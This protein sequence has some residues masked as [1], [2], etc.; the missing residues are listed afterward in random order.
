MAVDK[1]TLEILR[2]YFRAVVEDMARV[3]ER[4]SFTT[5]V[6]ETADFSTGLVAATGEY[7]AYPW[8]LGATVFLG[9]NQRKAIAAI[10]NWEEGDIGVL[11]DP[12]TSGAL[13]TH[14]PDIH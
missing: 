9:I 14:L 8:G 4:T 11:N 1:I 7:V 12:Y 2:N 10:P 13:S 3:V 5:F 6:K